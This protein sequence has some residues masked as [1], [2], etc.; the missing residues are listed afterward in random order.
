MKLF[1]YAWR[2]SDASG[3]EDFK[4][5]AAAS[6]EQRIES[7]RLRYRASNRLRKSRARLTLKGFTVGRIRRG[8]HDVVEFAVSV[9]NSG[10]P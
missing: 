5:G 6:S 2:T 9:D 3:A 10:D 4:G 1:E 7:G 8:P